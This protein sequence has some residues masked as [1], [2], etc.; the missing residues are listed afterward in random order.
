[1]TRDTYLKQLQKYLKGLP[2]E[3]YQDTLDYFTEYFDEMG[4]ENEAQAIAELGSPK[5][6]ARDILTNLYDKKVEAGHSKPHQMFWISGLA[7]LAAPIGIPLAL[8]L[9]ALFITF[10]ILLASA[11][12]IAI[13]ACIVLFSFGIAGLA[14]G[15]HLWRYEISSALLFIGGGILCLALTPL[16]TRLVIKLTVASYQAILTWIQKRLKG[17]TAYETV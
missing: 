2:Q 7:I 10:L 1:M 9:L 8:T 14:S 16:A 4:S 13:S 15:I 12:L 3:D 11:V 5:K 6:A 17:K